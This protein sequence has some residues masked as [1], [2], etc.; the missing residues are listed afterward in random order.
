MRR[1]TCGRTGRFRSF[2]RGSF[3]ARFLVRS[4]RA[5]LCKA[6]GLVPAWSSW[7]WVPARAG[8]AGIFRLVVLCERVDRD[9]TQ[10]FVCHR[11]VLCVGGTLLVRLRAGGLDAEPLCRPKYRERCLRECVS[12]QLVA[13]SQRAAHLRPGTPLCLAL[14]QAG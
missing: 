9:R 6:T 8:H 5:T 11:R 12:E 4:I 1:T 14:G 2:T 10:A 7:A 13:V 3:S